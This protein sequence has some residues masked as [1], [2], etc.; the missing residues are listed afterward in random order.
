MIQLIALIAALAP[1]TNAF[2]IE[3]AALPAVFATATKACAP[4]FPNKA[5]IF[6][7]LNTNSFH[8]FTIISATV[9]AMFAIVFQINCHTNAIAAAPS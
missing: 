8:V 4:D 7:R 1:A 2:A 5:I 6:L 3:V 9:M